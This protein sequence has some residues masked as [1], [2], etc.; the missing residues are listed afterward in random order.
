MGE[1]QNLKL[2]SF[3]FLLFFGGEGDGKI[4]VGK[5]FLSFLWR[6]GWDKTFSWKFPTHCSEQSNVITAAAQMEVALQLVAALHKSQF[7][8]R[9]AAFTE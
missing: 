8:V 9:I 4:K 6:W 7:T 3:F 1:R 5:S 2:E